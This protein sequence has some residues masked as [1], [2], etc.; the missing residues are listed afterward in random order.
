M[1]LTRERVAPPRSADPARVA[2]THQMGGINVRVES[3]I[4]FVRLLNAP[5]SRFRVAAQLPHITARLLGATIP[6]PSLKLPLAD[7]PILARFARH[8][9]DD[10][11][12]ALL[13]AP[14]VRAYLLTHL[15]RAPDITLELRRHAIVAFDWARH[16]LSVF[17]ETNNHITPGCYV[18]PSLF[19]PFLPSFSAVVVH[20]SSLVRDGKAALFCASDGG[21]KTTVVTHARSGV[22]LSDD[23]NLLRLDGDTIT[24][25][26]TAWGRHAQ[27][28]A[29]P[30]GGLFVL[31][32]ADHFDLRPLDP[33]GALRFLWAEHYTYFAPLPHSLR[34][35][36]LALLDEVCRAV[37]VYRMRFAQRDIDWDA[38][39]R[40]MTP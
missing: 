30:L 40:A 21:G 15:D 13:A 6:F 24:V 7:D 2:I 8:P 28:D 25:C 10:G 39:D 29:A 20:S 17:Y 22:I 4:F 14:P 27:P 9:T 12:S 32:K 23:H 26:G 31:E 35:R 33:L 36:A 37:P 11:D 16:D 5:F 19:A 3:D 34:L 18:G 1:A 38:I